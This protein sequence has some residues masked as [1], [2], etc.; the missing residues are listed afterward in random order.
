VLPLWPTCKNKITLLLLCLLLFVGPAGTPPLA[1]QPSRPFVLQPLFLVPPFISRRRKRPL[2]A[3]GG[4][5]GEN[6][7]SSLARQSDFH[8][9]AGFFNM[10]QSCDMEQTALLPLERKVCWGFFRPKNPTASA[11]FQ[12]A[13]LGTRGSLSGGTAILYLYRNWYNVSVYVDCLLAGSGWRS[14]PTLPTCRG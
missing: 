13:N 7:R 11:G 9:I 8:E 2:L 4:I 14:I 5:M 1:L 10:P 3:K 6:G 12:P